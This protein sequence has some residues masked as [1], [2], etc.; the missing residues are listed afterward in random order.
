MEIKNMA[1]SFSNAI[2]V[3]CVKGN[4]VENPSEIKVSNSGKKYIRVTMA[5]NGVTK[6]D[7]GNPKPWFPTLIFFDECLS[8]ASSLSKGDFIQITKAQLIPGELE[9][10][11]KDKKGNYRS[12]N[13][14]LM[15]YPV[16]TE[17][18]VVIP[19]KVIKKREVITP[20]PVSKQQELPIKQEFKKEISK[21]VSELEK[22]VYATIVA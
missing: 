10:P 6:E 15:I 20:K 22:E 17:A 11:Y 12:Q 4:L 5:A 8:F 13:S 19:V 3:D 2:S 14:G 7:P 1:K 18:G 9:A 16:R 21:E